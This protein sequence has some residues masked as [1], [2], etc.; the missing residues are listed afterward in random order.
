MSYVF[1]KH[2]IEALISL[3]Q[4]HDKSDF[5]DVVLRDQISKIVFLVLPQI[6]AVLIKACQE[7]TA[8]GSGLVEMAVKGLGR[9]LCLVFEDYERKSTTEI[10]NEDFSKLLGGEIESDDDVLKPKNELIVNMKKTREWLR[11]AGKKVAPAVERLK[12][13]RGSEHDEV[14]NQLAILSWNLLQK[15]LANVK[16]MVPFLLENLVMLADDS[17]DKIRDFSQKSLKKLSK[18]LPELN[19]EIAEL[20]S[21]HLTLMP[22]IILTGDDSEQT[23]GF[24]LLNSFVLTE[25]SHLLSNPAILDKFLNVLLSCCEVEVADDLLFYENN[26]SETLEDQFY[27]MKTP[28]RKL[29]NV[30]N[31]K[32]FS[33]ICQNIGK[34]KSAQIFVNKILDEMNSIEYLVLLIEVLGVEVKLEENQIEG[35]V[36]EFLDEDYWT[37][38]VK[39]VE[40][41]ERKQRRN[42]EWFHENTPGLY[43]SAVEVKLR[44]VP[45]DDDDGRS[46]EPNV[47]YNILSTCLVVEVIGTCA[48]LLK[49]N[50]GKFL[51]KTLLKVL[52]KA[53]NS[54][55]LIRS[56]GI[57]TLNSIAAALNFQEVSHLIDANSEN[58]LSNIQKLLKENRDVVDLLSIVFKFAK[59]SMTSSIAEIVETAVTSYKNISGNLKLF[60]LYVASIK[61]FAAKVDDEMEVAES[62]DEFLEICFHELE[63][64]PDDVNDSCPLDDIKGDN[65]EATEEPMEADEDTKN[66]PAHIELVIKILTSTLQFFA[67]LSSA[68][69]I[70]A[71]EIFIDALPTLHPF[72]D[73]FLPMIH[74]MWYPFTKQFQVK[75]LVIL[76]RS[77]KLLSIIAE[78]AKDFVHKRSNDDVI[79]VINKFLKESLKKESLSYSQEFKL[80]REILTGYGKL[81]IDLDVE[82]KNLNEI[83]DILL[84]YAKSSNVSLVK[85]C[86]K[87]L[88]FLKHHDPGL[89]V[90]KMMNLK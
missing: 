11:A 2:A 80:Q 46:R 53:G 24:T 88:E 29:K 72:D 31:S 14:R 48:T 17:N 1:R 18:I 81:A 82:G 20:F 85:E 62:W 77:F 71:H 33:E 23:A 6:S 58:L 21:S 60:K 78:L 67:S 8:K 61:D 68:E 65:A 38:Q 66:L 9:Y 10:G 89:V 44:D 42:E 69:V 41:I 3:M 47:K 13:I 49:S 87:S 39:A 26:P 25:N 75:N 57:S 79:P 54:N 51:H 90:F 16:S 64:S 50:F 34:S 74:Q 28:W 52:D 22:R 83:V 4:L 19:Q 36:E 40:K 5:N 76:Q 15:C 45:L 7:D 12:I 30:K 37:L 86:E 56:A 73:H 32:K 59:T 43:E 27:Q 55:F 63:K 84:K 35:I 70:L